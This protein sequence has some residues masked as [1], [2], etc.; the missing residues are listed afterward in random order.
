[1]RACVCHET[2]PNIQ[3]LS[4]LDLIGCSVAQ[5]SSCKVKIDVF[6]TLGLCMHIEVRCSHE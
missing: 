1:M 6:S 2:L 5:K 4:Q 3:S